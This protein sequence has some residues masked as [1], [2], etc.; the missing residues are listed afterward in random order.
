MERALHR[1]NDRLLLMHRLIVALPTPILVWEPHPQPLS[2]LLPPPSLSSDH[3][4]KGAHEGG[5]SGSSC[6]SESGGWKGLYT[7][8]YIYL[9]PC[10][11][12]SPPPS[13]HPFPL[14][15]SQC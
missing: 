3:S 15:R 9:P 10:S 2:P 8:T 6:L 5:R 14:F 7:R 4:T 13:S 11:L 1:H 12:P